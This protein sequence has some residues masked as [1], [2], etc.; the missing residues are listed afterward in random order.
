MPGVDPV[1]GELP[2]G[3]RDLRVAFAVAPLSTLDARREQAV[4]LQ[5]PCERRVDAGALAEL[6]EVELALLLAEAGGAPPLA[7]RAPVPD[8]SSCLITRSGRNSSRC[9]LRIVSSRSTSSS[10]NS[11]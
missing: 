4:L 3:G 11:R 7:L 2:A 10:L 5:R 9:S 8:A 1:L 6:R